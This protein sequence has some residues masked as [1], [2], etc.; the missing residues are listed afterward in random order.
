MTKFFA[1]LTRK[2]AF[3]DAAISDLTDSQLR[4][5][6]LSKAVILHHAFSGLHY[7]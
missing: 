1:S 3:V 6:G 5:S 4:R 2:P 7:A